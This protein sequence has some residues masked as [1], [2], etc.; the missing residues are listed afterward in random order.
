MKQECGVVQS[1]D[2]LSATDLYMWLLIFVLFFSLLLFLLCFFLWACL[3]GCFPVE[4]DSVQEL[5]I[6]W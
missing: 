3:F 6:R 5:V 2:T 1:A 4:Q